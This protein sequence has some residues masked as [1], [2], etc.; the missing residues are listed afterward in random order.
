MRPGVPKAL[1]RV[2][3]LEGGFFIKYYWAVALGTPAIRL[4]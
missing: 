4:T 1:V 3:F 2:F